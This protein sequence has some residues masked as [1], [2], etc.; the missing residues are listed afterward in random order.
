MRVAST[1]E[2]AEIAAGG[3]GTIP[4][5]V[6]NTSGVID[7]LS[8]RV[9]GI[10]AS[11]TVHSQPER[12]TLFP[13]TEGALEVH[14]GL[15]T[16]FPAGTYHV[17]LVVEGRAADATEAY[18]D[19]EVVVP[20][21]PAVSVAAKPSVVRARGRA[22]FTVTVA[23]EGNTPLEAALRAVDADRSLRTTLTPSTL[24]VPIG[25]A[26]VTTVAVRGPRQLLGSDRDRPLRVVAEAE[27]ATA[28]VALTLKQRSTFGRGLITA[29]ILL[30]IL[31]AWALAVTIGMRAVLGTD[32]ATKVAPPSYFAATDVPGQAAG[33]APAGALPRDGLL[34]AGVG[35]TITG[36][37]HG[38][39]DPAGVGRLTVEALRMARDGLV[40]VSSAATQSDGTYTLAGLFPGEYLL[41]VVADGY[42]S[43]WYPAA[44]ESADSTY[45]RAG[46]QEVTDGIDLA[47]AGQPATITGIVET[48]DAA[49]V[50]VTVTAVPTWLAGDETAAPLQVQAGA[51]GSYVLPNL[52]AP[53]SYDLTFEAEGYQPTTITEQVLGGQ[54]RLALDVTLGAGLGQIEGVVTDGFAL[55]GGV[56]VS[57]TL[58]GE[59]IVVGTPTQGRVG[60]FVIPSLPTPATYVLTASKEGH[61]TQT[62]VVA[63][64]AG[65]SKGDVSIMMTGGVGTITG[66]VVGT[67][68]QGIGGVT[69]V[70][71]G[72]SVGASATSL[73]AGDVGAF[74]LSGVQGSATVTLTFTKEGYAPTSIPVTLADGPPGDVTVTLATMQGAVQGRVTDDGRGVVGA[75]VEATDGGTVHSTVS[76][77][78]GAAGAGS[79]VI[80]DLPPGTYAVTIVSDGRVLTTAIVTV[81]QGTTA[82]ADLP[83]P[84]GR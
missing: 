82:Q 71:G 44:R 83:F 55:L 52:V 18:H 63:L 37:V 58:D 1:V 51:D 64:G 30:A 24:S 28:E 60:S 78:S 38:V 76:T 11:A 29:L 70:A 26:A 32:P 27:G 46:A 53:G 2:R 61:G 79:Y 48:G 50:A 74:T 17:T 3:S 5:E 68:G 4:L 67:N 40:L 20:P 41:R 6:I 73:T 35:A 62:I 56:T 80:P 45:V 72:T 15:P 25:R 54:Q 84:D 12:L 77:A 42:E 14:I 39:E 47:I 9:L 43:V 23:N 57:T 49:D 34:P 31:A 59:E 13:Q 8:V 75:R 65:E 7:A 10:P 81:L 16:A 19:V 66:H 33:G 69:V 36:T 22:L 21:A